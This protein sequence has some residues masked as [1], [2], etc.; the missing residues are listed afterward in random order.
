MSSR[1]VLAAFLERALPEN[2]VLVEPNSHSLGRV[3]RL[4]LTV[5]FVLFSEKELPEGRV[6][7]AILLCSTPGLWKL[8]PDDVLF[9]DFFF[10]DDIMPL[11]QEAWLVRLQGGRSLLRS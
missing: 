5:F 11:T 6:L 4:T 7:V 2:R 1:P 9:F 10:F 8:S 3:S